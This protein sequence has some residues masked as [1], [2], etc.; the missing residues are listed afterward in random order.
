MWTKWTKKKYQYKQNLK[1][2]KE[3]LELKSTMTEMKNSSEG[4]K[5]R[6]EPAREQTSEQQNWNQAWGAQGKMTAEK[7]TSVP[8]E[9]SKKNSD[10]NLEDKQNLKSNSPYTRAPDQMTV[11]DF[12]SET[13]SRRQWASTQ[14][15]KGKICQPRIVHLANCPSEMRNNP[16]PSRWSKAE[17]FHYHQTYPVGNAQEMPTQWHKG[18]P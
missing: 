8:N 18:M 15:G 17:V 16:D 14:R 11:I 12:S 3:I 10:L 5:G 4:S 1:E 2:T 9:L 13:G 6:F 7:W